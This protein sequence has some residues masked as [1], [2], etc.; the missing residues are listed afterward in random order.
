MASMS[1][2]QL[3]EAIREHNPSARSEFLL[4]FK[5]DDLQGYFRRLT[6][7]HDHRG[8]QSIWRRP[9][10]PRACCASARRRPAA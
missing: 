8:P 5:L 4:H 1:K 7:L 6:T 9:E 2:E 3:I 10:G